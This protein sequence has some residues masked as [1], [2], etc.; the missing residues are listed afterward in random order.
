M[1]FM[2]NIE[3]YKD[4]SLKKY[5]T[6]KIGGNA[7]FIFVCHNKSSLIKVCKYCKEHNIKSN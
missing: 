1:F 5:C 2:S 3:I 7:D 6:F 4:S